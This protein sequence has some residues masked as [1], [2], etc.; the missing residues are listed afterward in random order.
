VHFFSFLLF[1]KGMRKKMKTQTTL[2][3]L[4]R[5]AARPA[6]LD[7]L[8]STNTHPFSLLRRHAS[9]D[10]GNVP[11][12]DAAA[13]LLARVIG[14]RVISSYT[15]PDSTCLWV[16]ADADRAVTTILRPEDY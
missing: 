15:L 4:G 11:P 13:N 14:A 12:E 8:A 7:A 6:A 16:I 5:L 9:G 2:Q 1:L 3:P 10:W